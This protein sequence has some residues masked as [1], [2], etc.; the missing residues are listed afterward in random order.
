V[1]CDLFMVLMEIPFMILKVIFNCFRQN[2]HM[3]LL[4]IQMLGNEKMT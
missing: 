2:N 3:R 1:G 4:L